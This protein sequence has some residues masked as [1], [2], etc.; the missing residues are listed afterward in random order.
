MKSICQIFAVLF[1]SVS[2]FGQNQTMNMTLQANYDPASENY[3]DIWGITLGGSEYAI[4]GSRSSIYIV[5]VTNCGSPVLKSSFSP[6]SNTTWR[7]F[8]TYNGYIFGVCDSCTEGLVVI[9]ANCATSGGTGCLVV[10]T[11][12]FFRSAHNIFIDGDKL[13]A[14]GAKSLTHPSP[15]YNENLIVLDISNPLVPTLIVNEN[16]DEAANMGMTTPTNYYIHDINVFGGIAYA[17][18]GNWQEFAM[19]DVSALPTIS[20]IDSYTTGEYC[21]SSWPHS[22]ISSLH[23]VCEEVPTQRPIQIITAVPGSPMSAGTSFQ[24]SIETAGG[25]S[26]AHN[27]FVKGDSLFVSNY[28]DGLKVYDVSPANVGSPVLLG[29]YDTYTDNDGSPYSGLAGCWGS[30]PFF[31]SGCQLASDIKYGLFTINY[32][33]VVPVTWS[34]FNVRRN[35]RDQVVLNWSTETEVNNSHFSILRSTE[36]IDFTEIAVA[37][38]GGNTSIKNDYEV[39]DSDPKP[40]KNFYKIRQVDHDGRFT[41]TEIRSI[42]LEIEQNSFSIS[43]NPGFGDRISLKFESNVYNLQYDIYSSNGQKVV[44]TSLNRS[45]DSSFD[46]NFHNVLSTGM[47]VIKLRHSGNKELTKSFIVK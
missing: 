5:D 30:Y 10:Q 16:L 18:H 3:N 26:T 12:D 19:W 23:Y 13:Y 15:N 45:S 41:D 1:I 27:V 40:G 32:G 47:Y 34:E 44:N 29:Y 46:L 42:N 28:H 43:P 11:T 22:T 8:K 31:S 21:H 35:D 14:V 7:D 9:D 24:H 6:G 33:V 2:C 20:F 25:N 38:G 37:D 4:L 17:S 36:G 39:V